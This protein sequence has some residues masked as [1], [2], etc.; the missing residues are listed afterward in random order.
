MAMVNFVTVRS[1]PDGSA[2]PRY[3]NLLACPYADVIVSSGK[4]YLRG[5]DAEGND[6]YFGDPAGY[7]SEAL[8]NTALTGILP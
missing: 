4:W 8:A 5:I 3:R 2:K 7:A 6:F 1:A